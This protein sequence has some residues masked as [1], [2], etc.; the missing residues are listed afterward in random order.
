ML[1]WLGV[2][3][4]LLFAIAVVSQAKNAS[5]VLVLVSLVFG[6]SWEHLEEE[7]YT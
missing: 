5:I 3:L 1:I 7:A 2:R 4:C 6:S